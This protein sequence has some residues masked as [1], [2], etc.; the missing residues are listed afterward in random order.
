MSDLNKYNIILKKLSLDK[1]ELIR[2]WRND[3]K[4]SQY[5]DFKE[6]ITP[7]MQ[8]AWFNKINNESNLYYIINYNDKEIGLVYTKDINYIKKNAE[9][10]IFIYDDEYLLTDIGFRAQLC[11][12][13]YV[14]ENLNLNYLY[15]YVMSFNKKAIR[16]SKALGYLIDENQD[17]E[18]KQRYTL[19]KDRY[20]EY[21]NKLLKLL[22]L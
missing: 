16:F 11:N 13:D 17:E 21:K 18:K 1:I 22:K 3:P 15:G 10:G 14:F 9:A 8:S 12:I 4:I 5:M 20:L 6:Y 2:N 7:E 19:T